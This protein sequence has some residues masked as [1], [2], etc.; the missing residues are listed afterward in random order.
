MIMRP[1]DDSAERSP[2]VKRGIQ[3]S[4][5]TIGYNSV[6]AVA[7]LVAGVLAN[8]VS[9]VGFGADSLIEVAAGGVAQWRLRSD[10]DETRRH[11]AERRA[12]RI[13]GWSFLALAI[14]ILADSTHSLWQHDAPARSWF[15]M[16]ILGLS[17]VVMPLLARAKRNVA[18]RLASSALEAEATQTSLCA[19]L[20][21]IALLGV[22]LN[23]LLG[24]WWADPVAALMMVP[25]VGNEAFEGIRG[26]KNCDAG[27]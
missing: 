7:S 4:Y 14:Y 17:I 6:E 24:W 13:I 26:E 2:L 9:L 16:V 19:Y 11:A 12:H 27:C 15:G 20:S 5:A 22:A 3:L 21:V 25:I 23:W 10:A 18:R 1:A 8:S